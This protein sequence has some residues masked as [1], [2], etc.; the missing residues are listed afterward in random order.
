LSGFEI[1]G[2]LFSGGS[3][4]DFSGVED[5][6]LELLVLDVDV[7]S[8]DFRGQVGDFGLSVFDLD[9]GNVDSSVE[10]F[11]FGSTLLFS[12][13]VDLV[14]VLLLE[15]EVG[16]DFL[17]HLGD[18]TKGGLVLELEVDGIQKVLSEGSVFHI[19]QLGEDVEGSLGLVSQGDGGSAHGDV[20][21]QEDG[22]EL[23]HCFGLG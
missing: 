1:G 15:D 18:V 17:Q 16:S 12:F 14:V 21:H 7:E 3:E 20:E 22:N 13:G 19:L 8:V 11:D 5:F 6:E 4:F 9:G 2:I 10:L 23:V